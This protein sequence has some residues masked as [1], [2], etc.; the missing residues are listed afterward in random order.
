MSIGDLIYL[1]DLKNI[2]VPVENTSLVV[3]ANHQSTPCGFWNQSSWSGG[4]ELFLLSKILAASREH[5]SGFTSILGDAGY[6]A[7]EG[8]CLKEAG[9]C[10]GLW[11]NDMDFI[12]CLQNS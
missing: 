3:S 12:V 4:G 7:L 8:P 6:P 9:V 1:G 2:I 11:T 10:T 5:S